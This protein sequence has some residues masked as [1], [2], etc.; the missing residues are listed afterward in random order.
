[1]R[2]IIKSVTKVA[3]KVNKCVLYSQITFKT[4][5]MSENI[6]NSVQIKGASMLVLNYNQNAEIREI[7]AN[8]NQNEALCVCIVHYVK[9]CGGEL[10]VSRIAVKI[11]KCVF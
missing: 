9:N 6:A 3:L 2:K 4:S 11:N 8:S 7:V 1:M 5:R 10:K